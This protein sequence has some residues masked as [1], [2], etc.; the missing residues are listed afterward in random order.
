MMQV[1][2]SE[3]KVN[4]GK[5]V[6]KA[7]EGDVFIT[8]NGKHIAKIVSLRRNKAQEME[9]LFGIASLPAAYDDPD[10]DPLYNNLKDERVH[11]ENNYR[12]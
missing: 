5:Y 6:D 4:V 1:A 2:L 8:R 3:L 10:F 12:Q 9:R 11:H 7:E